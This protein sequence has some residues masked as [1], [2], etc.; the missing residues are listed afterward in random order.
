MVLI[1]MCLTCVPRAVLRTIPYCTVPYPYRSGTRNSGT[2]KLLQFSPPCASRSPHSQ[3]EQL[4]GL[5][6]HL[7]S[8]TNI[9]LLYHPQRPT[10]TSTVAVIH[11]HIHTHI[12]IHHRHHR[13]TRGETRPKRSKPGA[14][15]NPAPFLPR[16]A[17]VCL[18]RELLRMTM[19]LVRTNSSWVCFS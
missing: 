12:L 19:K 7:L 8:P 11:I 6:V 5:L 3:W 2:L 10:L 15:T 1:N 14:Q 18:I 13:L 4:L 9:L 16:H 17:S